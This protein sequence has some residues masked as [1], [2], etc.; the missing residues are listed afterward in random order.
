MKSAKQWDIEMVIMNSNTKFSASVCTIC[1]VLLVICWAYVIFTGRYELLKERP[2]VP[3]E[4]EISS[5]F[6]Q[7]GY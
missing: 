1:G 3:N 2:I 4:A 6:G 7:E 5:E